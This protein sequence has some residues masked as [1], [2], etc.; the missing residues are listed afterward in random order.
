LAH[1]PDINISL[2]S[3]DQDN[4][5]QVNIGKKHR[6][7]RKGSSYRGLWR[8]IEDGVECISN[9]RSKDDRWAKDCHLYEEIPGISSCDEYEFIPGMDN[10]VFYD[11]IIPGLGDQMSMFKTLPIFPRKGYSVNGYANSLET[12]SPS[13]REAYFKLSPEQRPT[14]LNKIIKLYKK[15]W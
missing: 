7:G 1:L 11:N 12:C 15:N 3:T 2:T 6:Y 10:F 5:F 14:L 8:H 9:N 4:V 13:V